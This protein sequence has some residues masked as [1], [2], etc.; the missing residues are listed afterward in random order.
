[1]TAI[2]DI[3]GLSADAV[4]DNDSLAAMGID[5]MQLVEVS[6]TQLSGPR[7]TLLHLTLLR[8]LSASS[9]QVPWG[10][11]MLRPEDDL[12]A[13]G[14]LVCRCGPTFRGL[15]AGPCPWKR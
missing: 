8:P 10:S 7:T 11:A 9:Y 15:W 2:L 12:S 5:S 6:P 14:M 3:M 13:V 4:S 1:M